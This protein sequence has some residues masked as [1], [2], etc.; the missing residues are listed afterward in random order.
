VRGGCCDLLLDEGFEGDA[1]LVL[2]PAREPLLDDE[3]DGTEAADEADRRSEVEVRDDGC[4]G[5]AQPCG[6]C[7]VH[8]DAIGK[9]SAELLG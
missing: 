3:G 8:G 2:R 6:S 9:H 7:Q 5:G 1:L 4:K